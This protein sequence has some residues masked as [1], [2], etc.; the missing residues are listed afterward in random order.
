MRIQHAK[1]I[2]IK[3]AA[4]A[5]ITSLT[6]LA[7]VPVI[8][9]QEAPANGFNL[10]TTPVVA[11]LTTKPGASVT[12]QIQVKNNNPTP[13]PIKVSLLKFESNNI[14]GS[15]VLIEPDSNDEF[16]KWVTFSEEKFNAEP[17]VW[18]T[19]DVTISPSATAAFGYYYTVV[20][21]RDDAS[22][23]ATKVTNLNGAVAVPILLNVSA[24]GEVRKAD[25]VSFKSDRNSYEFLPATFTVDL[26]NDGNTHVAPRGNIFITKGGKSMGMLEVNQAKGNILPGTNRQFSAEWIDGSP[27]YKVKESDGKTTLNQD[28]PARFLSWENFDPSKVRFGKFH[29]KVAL[30][31][32]DGTS[33]VSTEA[34]LDFWVIPWRI[35]GV[36][37]LVTVFVAAGL[38]ALVIRPIRKGV[39]KLPQS[40]FKKKQ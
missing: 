30:V 37:L 25:V 3:A 29:A 24:P 39:K 32:D 5:L 20:F 34:E 27:S 16:L 21:T 7:I 8:F 19:I 15:P 9:A 23:D 36:A 12:T 26:K 10:S 4:V 28:K 13:E 14:N 17:N 1:S 2:R 11:N 18:R 33:D 35:L 22:A 31:Y 6:A 40:R 38:W